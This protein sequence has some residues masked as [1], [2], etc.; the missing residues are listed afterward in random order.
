MELEFL[1]K[2]ICQRLEDELE[3]QYKKIEH[4]TQMSTADMEI[5]DTLL[6]SLKT[7]KTIMSMIESH[8]ER[9]P[10]KRENREDRYSR[11]NEK[12]E[13]ITKLEGMMK[14][15]RNDSEAIDIRNAIDAVSRLH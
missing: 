4:T 13:L 8:E 7:V 12:S 2:D 3:D 11:S 5:L 6:H 14:N 9:Y 1:L 15:V 10:V